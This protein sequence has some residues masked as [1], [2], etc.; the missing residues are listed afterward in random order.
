MMKYPSPDITV[1][2]IVFMQSQ[3]NKTDRGNHPGNPICTFK[4]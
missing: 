4:I 1:G 3:D 2:S